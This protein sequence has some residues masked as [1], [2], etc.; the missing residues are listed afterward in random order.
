MSSKNS[1]FIVGTG[2][3]IG[4]TYVSALFYKTLKNMETSY[5]KPVQ[6]GGE[7]E[8][9]PDVEVVC[10]FAD[11]PYNSEMC[12]YVMEA[13]LSPHLSAE[14][15]GVTLDLDKILEEIERR[16]NSY[17]FSVVEGAGGI[18][19]PL[20]RDG[21]LYSDLIKKSELPVVLVTTTQVGTINHTLL[22]LKYLQDM[23]IPVLGVVFNKFQNQFYE[24]D[25]IEMILSL[26]NVKNYLVIEDGCRDIKM[27]KLLNFLGNS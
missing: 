5:Y 8:K 21:Y 24:R 2:T 12:T 14:M 18:C 4:K 17:N 1:F 19:V 25:N 22:T 10:S 7:N 16:K 20:N 13:P 23:E 26:G 27:D 9:S 3:D 11:I 15:E 6:S